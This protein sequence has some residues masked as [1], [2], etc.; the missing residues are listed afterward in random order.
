M[1]Q[2]LV[3]SWRECVPPAWHLPVIDEEKKQLAQVA[4]Y[5]IKKKYIYFARH[6]WISETSPPC[7][8]DASI[9]H[10]LLWN[11]TDL[12]IQSLWLLFCQSLDSTPTA[13]TTSSYLVVKLSHGNQHSPGDFSEVTLICRSRGSALGQPALQ[14]LGTLHHQWRTVGS[15]AVA[16][17]PIRFPK[18]L[19]GHLLE[20]FGV[21]LWCDCPNVLTQ[22]CL[23]CSDP[24]LFL[25]NFRYKIKHW[26]T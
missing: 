17:Q 21:G 8:G 26:K 23:V 11:N 12:Q 14:V 3:H 22:I 13:F 15:E 10:A 9:A 24:A 19:F 2:H 6:F 1:K 16:L 20:C 25:R 18:L 4:W 7:P 5:E